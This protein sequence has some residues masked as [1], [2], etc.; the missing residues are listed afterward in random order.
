[1]SRNAAKNYHRDEMPAPEKRTPPKGAE[2]AKEI[3]RRQ[4][5]KVL[6][7]QGKIDLDIDPERLAQ[8]RSAQ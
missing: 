3:R 2:D 7:H 4:L 8:L 6:S 5:A 1:M